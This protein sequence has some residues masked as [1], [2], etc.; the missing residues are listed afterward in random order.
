MQTIDGKI[1]LI[2]EDLYERSLLER[3]LHKLGWEVT[4]EYFN[5]SKA[6]LNYLRTTADE[7]FL[8]ISAM[9]MRELSGVQ[10]KKEIDSEPALKQKAIPFIFMSNSA[11]VHEVYS[12]YDSIQGYFKKPFTLDLMVK[13]LDIIIKYWMLSK[14]PSATEKI[15]KEDGW[16]KRLA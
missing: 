6:A 8:V 10:L 1:V 15:L 12:A 4:V 13:M 2:D 11:E 9:K 14:H 5:N 3:N 16:V 7:I